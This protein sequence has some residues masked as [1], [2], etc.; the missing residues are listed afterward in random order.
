MFNLPQITAEQLDE[1]LDEIE[2]LRS[3]AK[4]LAEDGV[5]DYEKLLAESVP[6][7]LDSERAQRGSRRKFEAALAKV[8]DAEPDEADRL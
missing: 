4:F 3:V 5:I 7:N 1:F 8:A 2:G 6:L